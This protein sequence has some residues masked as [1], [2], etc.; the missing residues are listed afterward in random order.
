[1]LHYVWYMIS[2]ECWSYLLTLSARGS[3]DSNGTS[4]ATNS[5]FARGAISSLG[6]TI[7]LK[8]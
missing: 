3:R 2:N 6:S 1:M 8:R 7:S 4:Q 5:I